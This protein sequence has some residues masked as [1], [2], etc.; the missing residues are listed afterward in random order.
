MDNS[1]LTSIFGAIAIPNL[2]LTGVRLCFPDFNCD[3]EG[4]KNLK[5]HGIQISCKS[6]MC[7]DY[8]L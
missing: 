7:Y 4:L 6:N 8:I 5:K 2:F 1:H 3:N